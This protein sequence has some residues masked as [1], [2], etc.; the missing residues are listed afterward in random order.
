MSEL[1]VERHTL[2]I[3]MDS[4]PILNPITQ[5][6]ILTMPSYFHHRSGINPA[7]VMVQLP[8]QLNTL[9]LSH[10]HTHITLRHT[11]GMTT[12]WSKSLY[13]GHN[14]SAHKRHPA[15]HSSNTNRH[16]VVAQV[17]VHLKCPLTCVW[18]QSVWSPGVRLPG[19]L[20]AVTSGRALAYIICY[21][22][23]MAG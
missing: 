19:A 3:W 23:W 1:V 10:T 4:D 16:L 20:L 15:S 11:N 21:G 5:E 14:I 9:S 17:R 2:S 18:V 22:A 13:P 12:R 8:H 7:G 6:V